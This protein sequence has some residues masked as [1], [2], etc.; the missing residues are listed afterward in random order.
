MVKTTT[1]MD[2]IG[3]VFASNPIKSKLQVVPV[4]KLYITE[5]GGKGLILFFLRNIKQGISV[6]FQQKTIKNFTWPEFFCSFN[7]MGYFF[8]MSGFNISVNAVELCQSSPT[9][10]N[11]GVWFYSKWVLLY[12]LDCFRQERS[13][14]VWRVSSSDSGWCVPSFSCIFW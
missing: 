11:T 6:L 8:R 4:Y 7:I 2:V 10:S 1:Y 13:L 5:R 12:H 3:F 9:D 14:S